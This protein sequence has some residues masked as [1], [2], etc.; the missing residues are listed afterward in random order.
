MNVPADFLVF[1]NTLRKG[2]RYYMDKLLRGCEKL[3]KLLN[4]L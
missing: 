4:K 3:L 1:E 2:I